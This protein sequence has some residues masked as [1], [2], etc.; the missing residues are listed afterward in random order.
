MGGRRFERWGAGDVSDGLHPSLGDGA[1][2]GLCRAGMG[3]AIRAGL[4]CA[5]VFLGAGASTVR[6][7][8]VFAGLGGLS[9]LRAA[10]A[11]ATLKA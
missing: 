11:L 8:F 10:S 4:P 9:A 3:C 5:Y 7:G 6:S 2:S 1:L